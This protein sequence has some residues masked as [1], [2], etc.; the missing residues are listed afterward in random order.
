MNKY[1][2]LPNEQI[3]AVESGFI[4]VRVEV[5][6]SKFIDN[7]LEGVLD[8]LSEKATGTELLGNIAYNVV[9]HRGNTLEIEVT[10]NVGS[11]DEAE[12]VDH[13]TIDLKEFEVEVTRI[14]YGV[15][16][17][18]LSARTADE[19]RDIA[20]DDAGNHTYSEHRA[21]YLVSVTPVREVQRA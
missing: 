15:R 17:V 20:D 18:K 7:D 6:L 3:A 1:L 16:T 10:G 9:A 8:L 11:I 14:G 21:E 5:E 13:D 12:E 2:K 4:T 19:A